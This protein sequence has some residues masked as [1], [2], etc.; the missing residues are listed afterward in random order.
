MTLTEVLIA[1]TA[2]LVVI[3]AIGQ[4]DVT[5]ILLSNRTRS[6]STHQSEA[7]LSL[8][9]MATSLTQADRINLLDTG[10]CPPED[11]P[12]P[13]NIQFR[14]P[15]GTNF[16]QDDNY[17]WI[18]YLHADTNDDQIPDTLLFFD[19]T[20]GVPPG[21]CTPDGRFL[22]IGTLTIQYRDEAPLPPGGEPAVQ[23]NNVLEVA[24]APSEPTFT[25]RTQITARGTAYTK[26]LC[27]LAACAV[28]PPPVPCEPS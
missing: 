20:N 7:G 28:S 1:S 5:R 11:L 23:D 24:I 21:N 6:I 19:N 17:N 3:L 14:V 2:S 22:E 4:V 25:Y 8:F 16:E 12:C 27:G 10:D 26:D 18:Q 13:A 15:I 9:Q